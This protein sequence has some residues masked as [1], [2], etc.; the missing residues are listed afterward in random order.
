MCP[1]Q[2]KVYVVCAVLLP[3]FFLMLSGVA[4]C[5]AFHTCTVV[6]ALPT[7]HWCCNTRHILG[8][9]F[10]VHIADDAVGLARTHDDKRA[11]AM[12]ASIHTNS[13]CCM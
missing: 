13:T 12:N 2:R 9:C 8:A 10:A 5:L 3:F 11:C 6:S 1:Q 7:L 4:A